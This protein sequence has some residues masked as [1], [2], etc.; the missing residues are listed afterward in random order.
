MMVFVLTLLACLP[1][2]NS[3]W[4]TLKDR[5]V[6]ARDVVS[7]VDAAAAVAVV[8]VAVVAEAPVA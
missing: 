7:D 2:N 5:P 3:K 4:L 6:V 1:L 8:A